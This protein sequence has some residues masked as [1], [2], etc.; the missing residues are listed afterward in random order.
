MN[1]ESSTQLLL[2]I[3]LVGKRH[4]GQKSYCPFLLLTMLLVGQRHKLSDRERELYVWDT[5]SARHFC[6]LAIEDSVP[7]RSVVFAHAWLPFVPGMVYWRR[8]TISCTHVGWP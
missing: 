5:L 4:R 1:R 2:E 8:S 3:Y 6:D 7:N